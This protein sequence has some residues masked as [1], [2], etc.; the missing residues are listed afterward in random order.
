MPI[1]I[2]VISTAHIH[3]KSF[4]ENLGKGADSRAAYVI[5]DD[6]ADR[7][8]RYAEQFKSRFEPNLATVLADPQVHGF[9]ICAENT[10]HLPLLERLIPCGKP[11]F[12][13]KPLAT[14]ASDI[15]AIRRLIA[16]TP[17]PLFCGYFQP[18][19]GRNRAVARMLAQGE[20]GKVTHV[21]FR[22]AHHAAYGRWFDNPDL[23]WFTKPEL[24]GGGAFM[25][26][27]T[28]AVHLLRSLFGPVRRVSAT[29][30]NTCGAYPAV[31]DWG[32]AQLDFVS[33][34]RGTVEAAW[35]QQGGPGGL[36]INGS[37]GAVWEW[38]GIG[39]V[40]GKPGSAVQTVNA[41]DEQPKQVD[42][43]VAIIQGKIAENDLRADLEA[44]MDSVLIMEA[45]YRASAEQRSIDL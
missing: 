40:T 5:W 24:S 28:H 38:P 37:G 11:I 31:D 16:A 25:D 33:G 18:F 22:N 35:V 8:K 44:C 17:A 13:E 45:C 34:V 30:A 42:R 6:V 4:L 9:L 27:G 23:A 19:G 10:R 1:N 15:A 32:I 29:I 2:A 14:T 39:L 26:M 20:L 41:L 43:L 21:R 12:C 7:G 3:T 36:E